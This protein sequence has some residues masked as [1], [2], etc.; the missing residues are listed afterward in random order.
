MRQNKI[1]AFLKDIDWRFVVGGIIGCIYGMLV[2][3]F[4]IYPC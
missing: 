1:K 4:W 2:T 3:H